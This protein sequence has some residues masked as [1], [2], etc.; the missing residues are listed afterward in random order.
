[1]KKTALSIILL[2][3]GCFFGKAQTVVKGTVYANNPKRAIELAYVQLK[4]SATSFA[5]VTDASGTFT[6]TNVKPGNYSIEITHIQFQAYTGTWIIQGAEVSDQFKLETEYEYLD[7][8]VISSVRAARSA[9]VTST[10]ISKEQIEQSDQQKDFP[11][12]LNLTPSTVVSSDAGNGV[13]YTGIRIRGI[14][15][16]RVNV[17][18]NGIPLNDA[19]S[20]GVYWVNLPDLA[21]SAESVQIQRGIGTSSNGGSSLGASVNIRT[22]DLDSFKKTAI[23][24][25]TGSFATNRISLNHNSGRLKGN[26]G[27]QIRGS[28]IDSEGYIDRASSDLGSVNIVI[29]KYWKKASL[30]ANILIGKERTYQAWWGIPEPKFTN[31][32]AGMSRYIDQLYISGND[33]ENLNKSSGSTYNYYTY[34]NEVDNYNQNHY[35]LF[36]DYT[37]NAN[38]TI[39]TAGYATTGKG[40][41]EQFKSQE[42]LSDYGLSNYIMEQDTFSE[43]DVIRRRWLDNTLVGFVT[44]ANYTGKKLNVT[45]ATGANVYNGRH[46]GEAIATEFTKY[47]ALNAIYYDN[48]SRKIETNTYVKATYKLGKWLPYVDLQFRQVNYVFKGLDNNLEFGSQ[49][50]NYAF[51]NPKV[52]ITYSSKSHQYYASFGQGNREPVRDDFRNNKPSDWPKHEHLDN[53]EMGYRYNKRRTQVGI[54]LYHMQYVNQLVLTGAVNDVG[55]AVRTNVASSYRQGIELE[56]QFPITKKLQFG[57]N[58]TLSANKI[59]SFTEYVG[60]WDG[61]Y[62]TISKSYLNTDISFSPKTIGMAMLSYKATKNAKLDMSLK[63]VGQ[64]F[65]DNTESNA[66]MLNGFAT[67]N[68]SMQYA[69]PVKAGETR[70]HFSVYLNNI[71]DQSYAPNGYTFSGYM[72]GER[73]DFNYL[74]PMAGRNIMLKARLDL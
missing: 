46:F 9:P 50:V 7:A 73:Q 44:N 64:Q 25:G 10:N 27:Y 22:N 33:L 19:E 32:M 49:T 52:G 60:E 35:Q 16:T 29:G 71:L 31:D 4:D 42:A 6:F 18:I 55:D 45:V 47:E 24:L 3:T 66:R 67:V 26:W 72:A 48:D 53:V 65:L 41:F 43:A 61:N 17:T 39:N 34:A 15:P 58:F 63:H 2:C 11:F 62:E 20:Q 28:L 13:G 68:F 12:L 36:Y 21:S 23:V 8:A 5:A 69:V 30:K 38:W 74:Y 40:Y 37:V 70:L 59:E 1:M 14:D 57:G 54:T 51:F 56:G